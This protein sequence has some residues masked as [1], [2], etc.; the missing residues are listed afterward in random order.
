MAT[1]ISSRGCDV[2]YGEQPS[3]H[4][5][6]HGLQ[7]RILDAF[8]IRRCQSL[9][10]VSHYRVDRNLIF[11]PTPHGLKGMPQRI[12][13]P[14]VVDLCPVKQLVKLWIY[15]VKDSRFGFSAFPT[16][17]Q[18]GPSHPVFRQKDQTSIRRVF[19]FGSISNCCFKGFQDLG[20]QRASPVDAGLVPG[21]VNPS[22]LQVQFC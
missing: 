8:P 10:N 11:R 17:S 2:P 4:G 18:T 21:K 7:S 16:D 15:R 12:E 9:V 19:C 3:P 1:E 5:I 20:P 14:A 6:D 22:A 13:A